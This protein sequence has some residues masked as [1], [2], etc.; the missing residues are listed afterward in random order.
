[1]GDHSSLSNSARPSCASD[2]QES[3]YLSR[4]RIL[5]WVRLGLALIITGASATVV[6]CESAPLHHYKQTV[7]FERFWLPLWPLNL[8]LR[9]TNALLVCGSVIT[10]QTL[11]YMIV[12]ILPSVRYH[13]LALDNIQ[14]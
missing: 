13:N 10:F 1:M 12:A 11:I 14:R 9:Q 7:S 2:E 6:G 3:A 8:D 5:H 4:T